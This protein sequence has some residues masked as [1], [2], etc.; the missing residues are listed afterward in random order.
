MGWPFG[1]I[2]RLCSHQLHYFVLSE[3]LVVAKDEGSLSFDTH[4][5][6]YCD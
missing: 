6:E 3:S 5:T 2:V 4:T 1:H